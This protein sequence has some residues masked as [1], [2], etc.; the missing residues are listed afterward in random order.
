MAPV[1]VEVFIVAAQSSRDRARLFRR[2]LECIQG[3]KRE[4]AGGVR[5]G[6][7][8]LKS[9]EACTAEMLEFSQPQPTPLQN[10]DWLLV[11]NR[12]LRI[13]ASNQRY[14]QRIEDSSSHL[15]TFRSASTQ[16][17]SSCLPTEPAF[18]FASLPETNRKTVKQTSNPLR[19]W[20]IRRFARHSLEVPSL[21]H[22]CAALK[23]AIRRHFHLQPISRQ[24]H[25]TVSCA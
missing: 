16:D 2:E 23:S 11:R 22:L 7:G 10:L 1:T 20:K 4:T 14:L 12:M 15:P 5:A 6:T 25:L 9:R 18:V 8:A 3:L 17:T 21:Y 19:R 24:I 13:C